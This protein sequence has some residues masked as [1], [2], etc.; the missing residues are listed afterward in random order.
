[1]SRTTLELSACTFAYRRWLPPVLKDFTYRL[2]QGLT[3]LLGPNGAGKSTAL[4]LAA[5]VSR[6]RAGTVT[7]DGLAAGTKGYRQAVAW[8]PQH[9]TAMSGLTAREQVAYTGW[10]KGMAKADAWEQAAG[11]LDRVGLTPQTD[12][13]VKRLSGGQLRRVGVASA[14]VHGARVLLLDEPTAGM[15][16][17]QRRVFRELLQQVTD[18]GVQVLM[19]THDVTDLAE[20]ADHVTVLDVGAIAFSGP[21]EE[22]L[23]HAPADTAAGRTAEAAYSLLAESAGGS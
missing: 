3:I 16:P 20:E 22:F 21:T 17:R 9:I 4:R 5:S 19:S 2:P 11:A 1:M 15:D 8:M 6:P 18:A 10:L 12:T 13:K 7:F 14:L 23:A